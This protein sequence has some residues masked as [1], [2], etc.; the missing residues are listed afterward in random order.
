M[1]C[2]EFELHL[3]AYVDGELGVA[4]TLAAGAHAGECP[5]CQG[6]AEHERRFR[7]LLRRQP[8]ESAPPEFRARLLARWR[9]EA[10]RRGVRTWLLAATPAAA[11][12]G[13]V[14]VVLLPGLG[15]ARPLVQDLVATHIA[16]AQLERPAEFA[17]ED[18]T[19]LE[20]WFQ[21]RARLRITVPDYSPAGIRLVGGRIAEVRERGTA[22]VLYKKGHTLLSVFMVP[23]S[24]DGT[25]LAGTRVTYRG[26]EYLTQERTGYRTVSWTDGHAIF[27]LVSMLDYD[28]LLECADRLREA[29]AGQARL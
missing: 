7:L 10:R 19:Q 15:P 27:G 1:T 28:A 25:V 22:Y 16:Y 26:Q 21:E 20:A 6:L 8:R 3:P 14:L 2:Q 13:L 5:R 11:A 12:A 24:G 4:E 18:R 17:S 23:A 9:Q 29:R